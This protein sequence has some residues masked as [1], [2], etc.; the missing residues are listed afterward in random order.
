M[1]GNLGGFD[2]H[3]PGVAICEG[4]AV[5]EPFYAVDI[6]DLA[7]PTSSLYTT[8]YGE[9]MD[10]NDEGFAV[11]WFDSSGVDKPFF[12]S[13]VDGGSAIV[14]PLGSYSAGRA[15]AINE[16]TSFD[17]TGIVIG[18]WVVSGSQH[19]AVFWNYDGLAWQIN[20]MTDITNDSEA[21][22]VSGS[23]VISGYVFDDTSGTNRLFT[24]HPDTNTTTIFSG[25]NDPAN[26]VGLGINDVNGGGEAIVGS[27]L[28]GSN[29]EAIYFLI[30]NS[31][32]DLQ[33]LHGALSGI[34]FS[35]KALA[36]NKQD[37]VVGYGLKTTGGNPPTTESRAIYWFLQGG[38]WV[39]Q[40][41]WASN[42]DPVD[43]AVSGITNIDSNGAVDIV[44][45]YSSNI[46]K[47]VFVVTADTVNSTYK[48]YMLDP[49][50]TQNHPSLVMFPLAFGNKAKT[51]TANGINNTSAI[52]GSYKQDKN[53]FGSSAVIHP[54][55]YVPNDFDN[56]GLPDFREKLWS[57]MN[58]SDYDLDDNWLLDSV[59]HIRVGL[60]GAGSDGAGSRTEYITNVQVVRLMGYDQQ[61]LDNIVIDNPVGKCAER[62][63]WLDRWGHVKQKEVILNVRTKDP[64]T[65]NNY[66]TDGQFDILLDST[67]NNGIQKDTNLDDIRIFAFRFARVIDGMQFGNEMY[68][69]PGRYY[70]HDGDL[71]SNYTG[72]INDIGSFRDYEEARLA[73]FAQLSV[74]GEAARIGSALAGR[75]L[76][77]FSPAVS[78]GMTK[79]GYCGSVASLG[80]PYSPFADPD[81]SATAVSAL[82]DFANDNRL[83]F[84]QHTNYTSLDDLKETVDKI[85][86]SFVDPSCTTQDP[87]GT[88][89]DFVAS[90]ENGPMPTDGWWTDTRQGQAAYFYNNN[91]PEGSD[92]WV[93]F[94]NVWKDE[95][96]QN[97][98]LGGSFPLHDVFQH[99]SSN[100]FMY[101]CVNTLQQGPNSSGALSR[102]ELGMLRA[103]KVG[104]Y[105]VNDPFNFMPIATVYQTDA[106][107]FQIDN[108]DPHPD[109]Y[110]GSI[111]C[112]Q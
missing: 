102:T 20:T 67:A 79:T 15:I 31:G 108:F 105:C 60:F 55:L 28:N 33:D 49:G 7:D 17:M 50:G 107:T 71:P 86:G 112:P 92:G 41:L 30:T 12:M 34:Y 25:T 27:R 47:G 88:G 53:K 21:Q 4:Q 2:F 89:P 95:S 24:Y 54:C 45:D 69:G 13:P 103:Q 37:G 19:L 52:A 8:N 18:G 29:P 23:G 38:N 14:L 72:D 11:G 106:T 101:L 22:A 111:V 64:N 42:P 82:V 6:S 80:G 58:N 98:G 84:D 10:V 77:I 68:T 91:C 62:A 99:I 100:Q 39:A 94:V 16:T 61:M 65:N 66:N 96:L 75:P 3:L 56:N 57:E 97:G 32:T 70:F 5:Y 85:R 78:A 81:K 109:P 40:P 26:A 93:N 63:G 83:I 1:V 76:R 87:W 9:A 104:D 44:G 110:D 36:I 51:W 74:Q 48:S 35:S 73:I 46:N 59:E 90:L 43:S